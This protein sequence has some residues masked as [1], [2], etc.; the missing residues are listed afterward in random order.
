MPIVDF[1]RIKRIYDATVAD[2][3]FPYGRRG[4]PGWSHFSVKYTYINLSPFVGLV[5]VQTTFN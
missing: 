1:L 4:S 2:P 5:N 3:G